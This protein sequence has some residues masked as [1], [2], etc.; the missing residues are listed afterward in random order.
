M[1]TYAY[2]R[3]SSQDQNLARQLDAFSSYGVS[4][5]YVFCDKNSGK[6]FDRENYLKLLKKLKKGDLLIIKSIDRLGRNYD[7][8]IFEWNR[9][10][11]QIHA[12]ILVID[13]PLLDTRV[14][15]NN[16]VGK[17]ISDIV[18]QILS[19]VAENER[20]SIKQRQKEGIAAAKLRGTK[21]GRPSKVYDDEFKTIVHQYKSG[22]LSLSDALTLSGLSRCNFYYHMRKLENVAN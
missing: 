15:N 16:L 17:F 12:D 3:V 6:D 19:F 14:K 2:A 11:N 1:N 10:T 8:I 5:K 18:L 20:T 13:M 22:N 4:P 7:A 9:I 21:F